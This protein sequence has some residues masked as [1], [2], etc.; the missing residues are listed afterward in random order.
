MP[1]ADVENDHEYDYDN[2]NSYNNTDEFILPTSEDS[3][4]Y[5]DWHNTHDKNVR[6]SIAYSVRNL[7]GDELRVTMSDIKG[8]TLGEKAIELAVRYSKGNHEHKQLGIRYKTLLLHVWQRVRD[9]KDEDELT[10]ILAIH[11]EEAEDLCF[12]GRFNH[13]LSVLDGFYGDIWIDISES[14]H[15]GGIIVA[16]RDWFGDYY[17]VLL[18]HDL[19]KERLTEAGYDE[20]TIEPWLKAILEDY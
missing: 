18:H 20:D 13:T 1:R 12:T 3:T 11:L 6:E 10:R 4:F 2:D 19:A 7:L 17:D 15:I 8:S 5:G 16:A 9:S 14:A